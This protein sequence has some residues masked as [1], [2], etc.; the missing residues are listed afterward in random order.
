M[1]SRAPKIC[2]GKSC[3]ALVR[4]GSSKCDVCRA[5]R[6]AEQRGSWGS[7]RTSTAEWKALR[8]KVLT[9]DAFV[10]Q[11][12]YAGC[13]FRASEVDHVIPHAA[14]GADIAA[15]AA[16]VC[17]P[18]HKLKTQRERAY[19]Q[20]GTGERP[21][22]HDP[23]RM[24]KGPPPPPKPVRRRKQRGGPISVASAPTPI[25]LRLECKD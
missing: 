13:E 14:G 5:N 15:N 20:H 8:P 6:P 12:R 4:D 1:A 19:I 23:A 2:S 22:Q 18:C 25:V 7:G 17:S 16:A 21:W 9:R 10:C 24:V 11:L 3:T